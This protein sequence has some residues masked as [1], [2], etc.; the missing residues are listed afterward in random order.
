MRTRMLWLLGL[1][2][3]AVAAFATWSLLRGQDPAPVPAAPPPSAAAGAAQPPPTSVRAAAAV[4]KAA[5]VPVA[6]AAEKRDLAKMTPLQ[7][8]MYLSVRSGADWLSRANRTDGRFVYG[9][10]PAV[11]APMEGDHYLRQVGAAFALARAA[12]YTGEERYVARAT[13]AI[14][15]LLGDTATAPKDPQA[16]TTSLSP[17]VVNRLAAAGLLVLAI[18]ELPA[19]QADLLEKSDQL[20]NYVRKMQRPDGSLCSCD[21]PADPKA[22]GE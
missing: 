14:L 4:E 16:R 5:P 21:D 20:C 15:T 9:Y 2:P 17:A 10:L 1:L 3:L 11:N 19:P 12:R 8:Q 7:Q 18:H 22:T 13:Q 6:P